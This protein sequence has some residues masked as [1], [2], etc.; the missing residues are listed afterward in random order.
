MFTKKHASVA[1]VALLVA[2]CWSGSAQAQPPCPVGFPLGVATLVAPRG[3]GTLTIA[4][5]G[6][7]ETFV[8]TGLG[9]T[10]CITCGGVPLVGVP[11]GAIT[12]DAPGL[13]WCP[14]GNTADTGTNAAGCAT[15]T[16]TLC[17][18]G[19]APALNVFVGGALVAAG[20]PIAVNSPDLPPTSP[21]FVDAGDLAGLAIRLGNPALFAPCWDFNESGPPTIDAADLAFF[22]T[23]LGASCQAICP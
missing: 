23:T 18:S 12:V 15:F 5:G 14:G 11:A 9:L 19:C 7:G 10:V 20:V 21:G 3:A 17:G 16:G 1:A 22:A 6:R 2:A 13:L 4:P 8:G